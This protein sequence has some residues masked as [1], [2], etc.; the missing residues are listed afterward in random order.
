MLERTKGEELSIIGNQLGCRV[1]EILLPYSTPEDFERFIDIISPELRSLCSDNFTSHVVETMLRV[2]CDRATEHLQSTEEI[3]EPKK[4]KKKKENKYSEE[5]IKICYD[6]TLKISK[7]ALNNMEDF[8]WDSYANHILRSVIKCLSGITLLPGE[9]PKVNLFKEKVNEDKG[10]PPHLTKMEY[11]NV[12][13][14]F[15]EL[16]KEF[17]IRLSSWPQFKDLPYEN[18]TSA[19]LQ[20]L[21]YAVKNVDKNLTKNLIMKLLDESFAPENWVSNGADVKEDKGAIEEKGGED[22]AGAL[23][24]VFDK[25]PAVRYVDFPK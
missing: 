16:V 22:T 7:Y 24:P 11:K 14:E 6:F 2:A 9:K 19:L 8:I 3:E 17:A 13:E 1:I 18:L 10:I 23:P 15:K 21:L 4:K 25:Q 5:H 12:P 20:V